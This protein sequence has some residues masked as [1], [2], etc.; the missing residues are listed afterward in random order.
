MKK[1]AIAVLSAVC[2]FAL[3]GCADDVTMDNEQNDIV[4]EYM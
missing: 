1:I 4:A 3:A 2:V